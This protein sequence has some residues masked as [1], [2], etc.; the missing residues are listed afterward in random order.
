ME[1]K[2]QIELLKDEFLVWHNI[3]HKFENSGSLSSK[4]RESLFIELNNIFIK[5]F[6]IVINCLQIK[7]EFEISYCP[8]PLSGISNEFR[9]KKNK[10][11]YSFDYYDDKY[12]L[13]TQIQNAKDLFSVSD[14]YWMN[15]IQLS[16]YGE[17]FFE[18]DTKVTEIN[19]LD[20]SRKYKS[21]SNVFNLIKN[22]IFLDLTDGWL[23]NIGRISVYWPK[24]MLWS[25]VLLNAY[26]SFELMYKMNKELISKD[27]F[28]QFEF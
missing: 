12:F 27:K 23:T 14:D 2:K 5:A 22:F 13:T 3:L 8:K 15:L 6:S 28:H 19:G 26:F 9:S 10:S 25:D 24:S 4:E 1:I 7:D 21:K 20:I 18:E 17:L 11:I 16:N